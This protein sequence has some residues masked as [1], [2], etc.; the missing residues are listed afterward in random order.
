MANTTHAT[1]VH[2]KGGSKQTARDEPRH[3]RRLGNEGRGHA[4]KGR[5]RPDRQGGRGDKPSNKAGS[6][7]GARKN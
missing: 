1:T 4:R 7:Q 6:G 3:A 5:N 2:T